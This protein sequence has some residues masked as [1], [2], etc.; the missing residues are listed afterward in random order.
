[1][2]CILELKVIA[3]LEIH[4]YF[5]YFFTKKVKK[6]VKKVFYVID[7]DRKR[8]KNTEMKVNEVGIMYV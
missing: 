7:R 8:D 3:L 5:C 2:R 6:I 4:I 1:M